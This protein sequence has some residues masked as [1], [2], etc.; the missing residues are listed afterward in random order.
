[1]LWALRLPIICLH[2]IFVDH[3]GR[4][5]RWP[6]PALENVDL[7]LDCIG[8]SVTFYYGCLGGIRPSSRCLACLVDRVSSLVSLLAWHCSSLLRSHLLG[9]RRCS[10]P[11]HRVHVDSN[12]V[13][14]RIECRMEHPQGW[15]RFWITCRAVLLQRV[16]IILGAL[17]GKTA[18]MA[19]KTTTLYSILSTADALQRWI[20][21]KR[22]AS[23]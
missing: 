4:Q 14:L 8:D 19:R 1:M 20:M 3:L 16:W 2:V 18:W 11:E 10:R 9:C 21:I 23:G 12:R 22:I 7:R 13:M 17:E 6:F 15:G 5:L